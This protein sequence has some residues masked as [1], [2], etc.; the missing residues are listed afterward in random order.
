MGLGFGGVVHVLVSVRGPQRDEVAVV[1]G[2]RLAG[3]AG[4]SDPERVV[5][6]AQVYD[7]AHG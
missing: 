1:G 2:E 4:G 7:L 5:E 3:L 6:V